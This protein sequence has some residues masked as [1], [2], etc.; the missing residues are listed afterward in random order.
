MAA[1]SAVAL[2]LACGGNTTSDPTG[3][4]GGAGA[5]GSGGT[6]GKP[7]VSCSFG[8]KVEDCFTPNEAWAMAGSPPAGGDVTGN[9][10]PAGMIQNSCC[11]TAQAG[12]EEAGQ[13][14]YVFCEG[15]CC[16]RPLTV[17]GVPRLAGVI[18]RADWLRRFDPVGA[19]RRSIAEAWLRDARMEHASVASFA[20]FALELLSLGAP[21]DLVE[22]AQRAMGD[23]VEHARLCFGLAARFG[24]LALGPG[25]IELGGLPLGRSLEEAAV[26]AFRE[27]GLAE[28]IA[29]L[30]ARIALDRAEDPA[31]RVAL[32]QIAD[33]E[34]RH[35]ALAFRFLAFALRSGGASVRRALER[36][37]AALCVPAL[38]APAE[39]PDVSPEA[40][41]A[42]GRLSPPE[43]AEAARI[44]VREV[45]EPC[46]DA[47]LA[48][49][50]GAEAATASC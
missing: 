47:L 49:E 10:P 40:W 1:S 35:A 37:R 14:C 45:V 12:W 28:T 22:D 27:G 50:P 32:V 8:T 9:C 29:A 25:P 6:G 16:G 41:R 24:G 20:R 36:E 18:E 7:A 31:V 17:E 23:E 26:A 5:P 38:D 11:N 43:L 44:A 48:A 30:S 13:C 4:G 46:L 3:S 34:E 21:S 33:D 19:A 15:A 2:P 42:A 39:A